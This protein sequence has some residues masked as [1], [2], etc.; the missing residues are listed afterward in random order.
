MKFGP[1]SRAFAVIQPRAAKFQ[2]T[3]ALGCISLYNRLVFHQP[4]PKYASIFLLAVPLAIA[5]SYG[6][7]TI[8]FI[9]ISDGQMIR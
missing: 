4:P 1:G 2:L 6:L 8:E 9:I 3:N 7:I 5:F